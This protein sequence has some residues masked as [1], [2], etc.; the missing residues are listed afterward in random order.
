MPVATGHLV[1][2]TIVGG[3]EAAICAAVDGAVA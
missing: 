1:R 2:G 3:G